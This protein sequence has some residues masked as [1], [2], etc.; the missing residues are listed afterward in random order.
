MESDA[1]VSVE[2]LLLV[3]KETSNV[4]T[5]VDVSVTRSSSKTVKQ[6]MDNDDETDVTSA[7]TLV[8]IVAHLT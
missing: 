5:T 8:A 2:V 1:K 6:K 7:T 4:E 3:S